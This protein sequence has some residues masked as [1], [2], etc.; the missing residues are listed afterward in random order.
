[1]HGS[2]KESSDMLKEK[3]KKTYSTH[4]SFLYPQANLKCSCIPHTISYVMT[5]KH[6]ADLDV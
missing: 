1:M 4:R 2:A 5:Q 6:S 3:L